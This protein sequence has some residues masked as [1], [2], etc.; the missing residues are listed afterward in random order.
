MFFNSKKKIQ[1]LLDKANI[2]ISE[3]DEIYNQ[4]RLLQ[5]SGDLDE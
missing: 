2:L 5:L 3:E 4:A 1:K